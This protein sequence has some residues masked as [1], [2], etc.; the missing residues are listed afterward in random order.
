MRVQP[1]R[2][3][4]C[5]IAGPDPTLANTGARTPRKLRTPSSLNVVP[6]PNRDYGDVLLLVL[7]FSSVR[8]VSTPPEQSQVI[9]RE[10]LKGSEIEVTNE[11]PQ[12][13]VP[14]A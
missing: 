8:A 5:L 12:D 3:P 11:L 14:E 10:R 4:E 7:P 6:L 1:W 9:E 13:G 2:Q